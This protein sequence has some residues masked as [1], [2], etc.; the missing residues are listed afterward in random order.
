MKKVPTQAAE[1]S[2]AGKKPEQTWNTFLL[3]VA[4]YRSS[5]ASG[6][7]SRLP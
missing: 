1:M 6:F 7:S 4:R 3:P 5:Y 2:V